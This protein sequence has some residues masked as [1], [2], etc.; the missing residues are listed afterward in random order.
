MSATLAFYS[1]EPETF[2][3]LQETLSS[4]D[5]DEREEQRAEAQLADYPV[6]DVSLYLHFL[7][8]DDIDALCQAMIAE[9]FQTPS[10]TQDLLEQPLWS[11]GCSAWVDRVSP[12]LAQA[13]AHVDDVAIRRIARRWASSFPHPQ[14]DPEFYTHTSNA[15]VQALSALRAVSQDAL[16]RGREVLLLRIW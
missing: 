10:S 6:A 15:A 16:T 2:V 9:G 8:P 4:S 5:L 3:S 14:A 1:A 12:R 7:W 11:D 13:I